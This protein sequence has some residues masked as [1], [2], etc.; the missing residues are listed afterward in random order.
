MRKRIFLQFHM[1][2]LD[3]VGTACQTTLQVP[4]HLQ[5]RSMTYQLQV[6]EHLQERSMTYQ[7]KV[8]EHLQERSMT[9]QLQVP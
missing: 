7:F 6:P 3:E 9:Y 5:E 4:E 8:P 2:C 1:L